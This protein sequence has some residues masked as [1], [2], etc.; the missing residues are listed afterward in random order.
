MTVDYYLIYK[1]WHDQKRLEISHYTS[2]EAM[3]AEA[4]RMISQFKYWGGGSVPVSGHECRRTKAGK[5]AE[6]KREGVYYDPSLY[7][8]YARENGTKYGYYKDMLRI[9]AKQTSPAA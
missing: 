1:P 6:P 8:D 4:A 5:Y 2:W 9:K 7:I 3:E